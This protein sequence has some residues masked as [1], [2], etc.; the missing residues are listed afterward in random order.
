MVVEGGKSV[1]SDNVLLY[2]ANG[3]TR[4][5]HTRKAMTDCFKKENNKEMIFLFLKYTF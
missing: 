5:T 4:I 3:I 1:S 2:I